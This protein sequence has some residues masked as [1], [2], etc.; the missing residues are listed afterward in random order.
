[1]RRK[2][3]QEKGFRE[4]WR[5]EQRERSSREN[6]EIDVKIPLCIFTGCYEYS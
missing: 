3:G 6:M 2:D 4:R 5:L 1:M